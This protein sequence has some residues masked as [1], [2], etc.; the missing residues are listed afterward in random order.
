MPAAHAPQFNSAAWQNANFYNNPLGLYH[1]QA[2]MQMRSLTPQQQ[3]L[4]L[5]QQIHIM[6]DFS[7]APIS[8]RP[9][10][11]MHNSNNS[12][13]ISNMQHSN[14]YSPLQ[15]MHN[16]GRTTLAHS[17]RTHLP[18]ASPVTATAHTTSMHDILT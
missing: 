4:Q 17:Y 11:I 12:T 8:N 13:A 14:T 6:Q 10:N 15:Q 5:Q 7:T 18:K 2:T 3:Q 9:Q 1:Q 16:R